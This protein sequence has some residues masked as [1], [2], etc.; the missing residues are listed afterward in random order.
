MTWRRKNLL[1]DGLEVGVPYPPW[2]RHSLEHTR[3]GLRGVEDCNRAGFF[4][5]KDE[6]YRPLGKLISIPPL[7]SAITQRFSQDPS[8]LHPSAS[9]R[10]RMHPVL[11]DLKPETSHAA[12]HP[13][14]V[15]Q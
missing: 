7:V 13:F 11:P 10:P 14:S 15:Q 9:P 1:V 8:S 6:A 12:K 3:A 5:P 2:I 4:S